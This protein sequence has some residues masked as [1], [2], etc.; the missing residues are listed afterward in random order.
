MCHAQ[1]L[2]LTKAHVMFYRIF[3]ETSQIT[4][5]T[6][7]SG[8]KDCQTDAC[9]CHNTRRILRTNPL[10]TLLK[11]MTATTRNAAAN[12]DTDTVPDTDNNY[13]YT[14]RPEYPFSPQP[15]N[16]SPLNKNLPGF[17]HPDLCGVTGRCLE[18]VEKELPSASAAQ[19]SSRRHDL[20][21]QVRYF[22]L[23]RWAG[24]PEALAGYS[25]LQVD[26]FRESDFGMVGESK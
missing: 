25:S 24:H 14:S 5:V 10:I 8:A 15:K 12:V 3:C 7:K 17:H 20:W 4:R 22:A 26:C 9:N 1:T 11:I 13:N 23:G 19:H 18:A 16:A 2:L 6:I 21:L